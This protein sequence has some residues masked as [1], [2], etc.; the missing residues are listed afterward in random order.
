ML[1]TEVD[2][3]GEGDVSRNVGIVEGVGVMKDEDAD[4]GILD[5][6]VECEVEETIIAGQL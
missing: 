6:S 3:V 2:S 5:G 1:T 4:V